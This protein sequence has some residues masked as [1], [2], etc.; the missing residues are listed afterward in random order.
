MLASTSRDWGERPEAVRERR[1][2][3]PYKET[4]LRQ[5]IT[6]VMIFGGKRKVLLVSY[7]W[8]RAWK[9]E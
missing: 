8:K 1:R 7:K 6:I 2:K 9:D 3:E 4:K 5:E